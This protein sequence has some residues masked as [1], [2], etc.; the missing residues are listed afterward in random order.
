MQHSIINFRHYAVH[1]IPVPDLFYNWKLV[2]LDPSHPFLLLPTPCLW[3]PPIFSLCIYECFVWLGLALDSICKWGHM[4]FI[5]LCMTSPSIMFL[6]FIYVVTYSK[7]SFIFKMAEYYFIVH[8][9]TYIYIYITH[10]H[11]YTYTTF[12]LFIHP[13]RDTDCFHDYSIINNTVM[14]M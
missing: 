4:V 13:S 12:S 3:Q 8:T 7:I 11:I 9:H 5:F 2:P 14:Y 6:R 1:Y 10:T